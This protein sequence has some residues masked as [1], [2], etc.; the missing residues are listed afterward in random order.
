MSGNIICWG[1]R[2]NYYRYKNNMRSDVGLKQVLK[3]A[4]YRIQIEIRT[5][6]ITA[7]YKLEK[8]RISKVR[9]L[10]NID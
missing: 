6:Y 7:M 1:D 2:C 5:N 8:K 9:N 10:Q 3:Q 4:H